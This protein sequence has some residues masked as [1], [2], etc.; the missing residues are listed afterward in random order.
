MINSA[1]NASWLD[2]I[3]GTISKLSGPAL[4]RLSA[5]LDEGFPNGLLAVGMGSHG[6]QG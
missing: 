4:A 3:F 6:C 1:R 2:L 5:K